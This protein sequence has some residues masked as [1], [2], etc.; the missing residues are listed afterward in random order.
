MKVLFYPMLQ[1]TGKN[2]SLFEGSQAAPTFL[3]DKSSFK[4]KMSMEH[5]WNDSDNGK[6][7]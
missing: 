5:W 1:I 6:K 7:C 3:S 2:V 4:M